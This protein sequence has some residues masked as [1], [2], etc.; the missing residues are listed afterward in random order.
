MLPFHKLLASWLRF[1]DLATT[2]LGHANSKGSNESL[3]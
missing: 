1:D 2:L 3:N